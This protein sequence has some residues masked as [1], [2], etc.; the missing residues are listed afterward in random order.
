MIRHQI[1]ITTNVFPEDILK[2]GSKSPQNIPLF[3]YN[4]KQIVTY[5]QWYY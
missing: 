3:M 4:Y 1:L 2:K 5:N